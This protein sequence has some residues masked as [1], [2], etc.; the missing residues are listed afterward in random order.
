MIMSRKIFLPVLCILLVVG[1]TII[2][3]CSELLTGAGPATK[4]ASS[5]QTSPTQTQT[6]VP[7]Q[8]VTTLNTL[9]SGTLVPGPSPA[10]EIM[11]TQPVD[12]SSYHPLRVIPQS[13]D[14]IEYRT[15]KFRFRSVDY[16][17][18]IPVNM[19]IYRAASTSANKQ[20]IMD[21]KDSGLIYGQIVADPAMDLFYNDAIKEVR[22]LRYKGGR[23]LSDD[24]YLEMVVSFVQQ[25]PYDNTTPGV[26]YPIEVI[27]D[28]KG[29]SDEKSILLTG[30]LSRDGY[31]AGLLVFPSM[32]NVVPGI[33]I[34]L[35]TNKPSFR[36]FSDGTRDYMY[37]EPT[38]TRL[39]GFYPDDYKTAPKPIVVPVGNGKLTYGQVNYVMN[40]FTDLNSI[41]R[42]ALALAEKIE[43][44]QANNM[45]VLQWDFDTYV[46]YLKTIEAV[47]STNDRVK[48]MEE[49]KESELPHNSA[50]VSCD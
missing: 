43:D 24:E 23:T 35:T 50:C 44:A 41:K 4:Y 7:M 8:T 12:L 28:Q 6:V 1:C 13:G 39:I 36:V 22:N 42:N 40:I 49:I 11:A 32:K 17:L 48:A 14:K 25:I 26:R 19:S 29:D 34:H 9:A 27:Y 47:E 15:F 3:G 46:S 30:L 33:G 38:T 20:M 5:S 2:A 45:T 10:A 18:K 16:S 31:D 37:I 21:D